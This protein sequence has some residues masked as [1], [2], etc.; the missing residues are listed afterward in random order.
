MKIRSFVAVPLA[1]MTLVAGC[2][3]TVGGAAIPAPD[4]TPRPLTGAT[5]GHVLLGDR[6]LSRIVKRSL[7]IDPRFP[8]RFGGAEELQDDATALPDG[9]RGVASMLQQSVYR[10]ADVKEV[11]VETWRHAAPTPDVTGVT[12]GVVSL[13]TAADAGALFASFSRQWRGCDG[14]VTSLPGGV[15]RLKGKITNVQVS[16]SVLAATVSIG[17]TSGS[18]EPEADS[19]PAARAIGIRGN[20]L[21][22][23]EVDFFDGSSASGSANPGNLNG[24]AVD[25]ARAMMDK[26]GALI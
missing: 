14:A 22:E 10:S 12:E 20:C 8:P 21:I 17:W 25:I 2:T 3:A 23:V 26:I 9:C 5:V 6:A 4:V 24:T 7:N 13:P 16:S 15:F 19:I 1:A 18:A 11:A